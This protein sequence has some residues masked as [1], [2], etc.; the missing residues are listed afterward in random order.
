M[1]LHGRVIGLEADN[2]QT[3]LRSLRYVFSIEKIVDAEELPDGM[4]MSVRKH[5][6][7]EKERDIR[8]KFKAPFENMAEAFSIGYFLMDRKMQVRVGVNQDF[9]TILTSGL[10][11]QTEIKIES[12]T[13]GECSDSKDK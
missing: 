5:G 2:G 4:S 10:D 11:L 12:L 9:K 13:I 7:N 3:I 1:I 8:V 6:R